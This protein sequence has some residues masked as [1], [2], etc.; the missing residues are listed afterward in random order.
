MENSVILQS[1]LEKCSEYLQLVKGLPPDGPAVISHLN[2]HPNQNDWW[3]GL[4]VVDPLYRGLG[5]GQRIYSKFEKW[6]AQHRVERIWAGVVDANHAADQSE[7]KMGFAP[8][9]KRQPSRFGNA[10][11]R[12]ITMCHPL[13][14]LYDT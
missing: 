8:V 13:T 2:D 1:L 12:V 5:L 3:I 7:F 11:H 9:E 10:G 6:S 4:L 14:N